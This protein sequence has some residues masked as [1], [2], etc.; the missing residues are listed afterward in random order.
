MPVIEINYDLHA[1]DKNYDR[2]IEKVK[3]FGGW[4]HVLASCWLVAGAYI[5]LDGVYEA[6]RSAM[7]ANDHVLVREFRKPYRGWLR[8]EVHD[9]I[10]QHA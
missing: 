4:C 7:D 5:T 8:Q 10:D 1:P 6:M 3:S 9:W 2:V